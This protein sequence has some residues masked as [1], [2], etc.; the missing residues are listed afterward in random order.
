MPELRPG[1]QQHHRRPRQQRRSGHGCPDRAG[2]VN[3][4]PLVEEAW[5]VVWPEHLGTREFEQGVDLAQLK[6]DYQA[7]TGGPLALP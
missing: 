3:G 5:V 2:T 7:L 6:A 1:G 4:T